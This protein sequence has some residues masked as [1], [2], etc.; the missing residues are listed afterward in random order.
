[1]NFVLEGAMS[2]AEDRNAQVPNETRLARPTTGKRRK[3]RWRRKVIKRGVLLSGCSSCGRIET[4]DCYTDIVV[5]DVTK[6]NSVRRLH[7][8]FRVLA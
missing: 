8:L 7:Y 3:L 4:R 2:F 5:L 6:C 1:M